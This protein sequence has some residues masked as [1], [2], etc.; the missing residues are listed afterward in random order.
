[1]VLGEKFPSMANSLKH[2]DFKT[3]PST[4]TLKQRRD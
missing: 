2:K 4:P 1:M 3:N